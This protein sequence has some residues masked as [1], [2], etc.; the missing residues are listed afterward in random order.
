MSLAD[1]VSITITRQTRAVTRQGFGVV[2]IVGPNA[3]FTN[4]YQEFTDV[5]DLLEV[6]IEED[7]PEYLAASTLFAQNPRLEKFGIGRIDAGDDN[8]AET[9]AAI[10]AE[11][12][13]WYGLI[14]CSHDKDDVKAVAQWAETKMKLYGTS[15]SDDNI[16]N[17]AYANDDPSTGSIARQLQALKYARTFCVYSPQAD[18]KY[19][20]A[21]IFG[22]A[23]VRDAGSY[24]VK[25]KPASGVTAD[26]L[27]STQE[28]NALAKNCNVYLANVG[29]QDILVNGQ[30]AEGEYIDTIHFCDW[31]KARMIER[32]Y[33]RFVNLD[34]VPFTDAG[35]AVVTSEI[36]AQLNDGINAG[37]L[38]A[39]P[40]PSVTAPRVSE[41]SANDKANRL[42]PDIKFEATL[43]GAIHA[44]TIQGTLTL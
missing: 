4:R 40:A 23:L 20:E 34:K 6:G 11:N 29:G 12:D 32:I 18:T 2:C 41:I 26:A 3:A 44:T 25:F 8:V 39:D 19:A 14:Y 37:G 31:L 15:S 10:A 24:T 22:Q 17:V 42:L 16:V 27:T 36:M 43:A 13:S 9:L 38:T 35:I 28:T 1:I 30:V 21:A 33:S 5:D 7:D